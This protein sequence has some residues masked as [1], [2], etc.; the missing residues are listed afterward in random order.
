MF[1]RK[2]LSV[3]VVDDHMMILKAIQGLL[4]SSGIENVTLA[5]SAESAVYMFQEKK[6]DLVISDIDMEEINGLGL[7]KLI[8]MQ[9]TCANQNTP[10][11]ILTSHANTTAIGIAISLDVNG[12]LVK[13]TNFDQIFE[14]IDKAMNSKFKAKPPIAYE[15]ISTDL[16][17]QEKLLEEEAKK[18]KEKTGHGNYIL[19]IEIKDVNPGMILYQHI[20]HKNGKIMIPKGHCFTYASKDRLIELSDQLESTI[21]LINIK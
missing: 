7:L 15:L 19:E 16:F 10:V 4:T 1:N 3:L 2:D 8:R 17:A 21:V 12:F 11:I 18:N 9:K 5:T 14:K 20:L 13:P 6:F